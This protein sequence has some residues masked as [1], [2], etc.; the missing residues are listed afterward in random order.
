MSCT[1]NSNHKESGFTLIEILNVIVIIGILGAVGIP[2]FAQYK[3]KAYDM[4]AKR[5]LKDM[6]LLCNAFWIDNF[7]SQACDLPT[8]KGTYYGFNQ[9][10]DVFATLP[11]APSD[12]FCATAKHSS[13]PN[14]F[15]I[16]NASF[17][18]SGE[19]CG[20]S[21]VNASLPPRPAYVCSGTF[22]DPC[23]TISCDEECTKQKA[24]DRLLSV[25][26][27]L[28]GLMRPSSGTLDDS[29]QEIQSRTYSDDSDCTPTMNQNSSVNELLAATMEPPPE[30]PI[31]KMIK[32]EFECITQHYGPGTLINQPGNR[33]HGS[34]VTAAPA[35]GRLCA[36]GG[37]SVEACSAHVGTCNS[38]CM[39]PS[40]EK[41]LD[42]YNNRS[43]DARWKA[44]EF[45]RFM[46]SSVEGKTIVVR[47]DGNDIFSTGK[48]Y[49]LGTFDDQGRIRVPDDSD[50]M[51]STEEGKAIT[52]WNSIEA[53][54]DGYWTQRGNLSQDRREEQQ[55]AVCKAIPENPRCLNNPLVIH[56]KEAVSIGF[57]HND[58]TDPLNSTLYMSEFCRVNP[59]DQQC[60]PEMYASRLSQWK[61]IPEELNRLCA[62]VPDH[63]Y[64]K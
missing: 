49:T 4:H 11:P 1:R 6:H 18:S 37:F 39:N 27:E 31:A 41:G 25:V 36:K 56:G 3:N 17:I 21:I 22:Q 16:N 61:N 33:L 40:G 46:N 8:I 5:A 30:V 48:S 64:C 47:S 32:E 45:N 54:E 55:R 43:N 42:W 2:K 59:G 58:K 52:E 19:N 15:S 29:I 14:A 53:S 28:P 44:A 10:P 23:P 12:S 24:Q 9:N 7:P 60:T 26:N 50:L 57:R 20:V 51:D 35:Q 63:D 38:F 13:S 34:C 62:A